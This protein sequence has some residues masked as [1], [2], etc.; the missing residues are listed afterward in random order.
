MIRTGS[1]EAARANR[2]HLTLANGTG[3]WRSELIS[4]VAGEGFAPQAF[5]V[6]QDPGTVILP[7]FHQQDQF[8]VVVGGDGT[9]GRHAVRPVSVHYA[10]KHTG[11]GP[12]TAG[13]QGLWYFSLRAITDTGAQFLPQARPMMK[14]F[15]KRN[16]MGEPFD[17]A[18]SLPALQE[19]RIEEAMP[20]QADGIGAWMLSLPP[21]ATIAPPRHPG[22]A[23]SFYIV[24]AGEMRLGA[25]RLPHLAAAF[26]S[27]D[28]TGFKLVAGHE[29]LQV[30]A[31]QY[32]L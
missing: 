4:S 23:A 2:R 12:I 19:V 16:L 24:V 11:Y 22:G 29:G 8:Q 3:Y 7:H 18:S 9:L 5:L 31:L 32:S 14:N 13:K 30:L 10:G 25:E 28:E 26:V 17:P 27:A 21:G 1:L 15:P 20:A 6:E